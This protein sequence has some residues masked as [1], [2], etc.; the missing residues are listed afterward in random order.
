VSPDKVSLRGRTTIASLPD[1]K[2]LVVEDVAVE[3][4]VASASYDAL[5]AAESAA[6]GSLSKR[7]AER[8]AALPAR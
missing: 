8:I 4:P 2:A 5:V 1:G 3:Q 7:I 6:L